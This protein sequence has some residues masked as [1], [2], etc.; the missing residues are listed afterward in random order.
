MEP[1]RWLPYRHLQSRHLGL[2]L[3][4]ARVIAWV[5]MLMVAAGVAYGIAV[6]I[7]GSGGLAALALGNVI[8]LI[9]YGIA[10]L[11]LGGALAALVGIEENQRRRADRD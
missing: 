5:G 3:A 10:A 7:K 11:A 8:G 1:R 6:A 2:A 9:G 4:T